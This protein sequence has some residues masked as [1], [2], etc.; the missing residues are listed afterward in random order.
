MTALVVRSNESVFGH[1]RIIL[2]LRSMRFSEPY[3]YDVNDALLMK[4]YNYILHRYQASGMTS[5][6]HPRYPATV[7]L[8]PERR[9]MTKMEVSSMRCLL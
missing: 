8:L 3:S 5:F 2:P 4:S 9:T 7:R 6:A 1:Y